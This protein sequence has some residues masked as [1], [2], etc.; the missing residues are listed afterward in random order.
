MTKLNTH[1]IIKLVTAN[2]VMNRFQ[3]NLHALL[4]MMAEVLQGRP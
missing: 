4:F 3:N 2:I 1:V